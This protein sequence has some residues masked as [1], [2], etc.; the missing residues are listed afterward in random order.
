MLDEI[1][2]HLS[3]P[4][5]SVGGLD[6]MIL[7]VHEVPSLT[8]FPRRN[9]SICTWTV[10]EPVLQNGVACPHEVVK[11]HTR[12]HNQPNSVCMLAHGGENNLEAVGKDAKRI[13]N[14]S[15]GPGKS[16]IEDSLV[17][18]QIPATI[19]LHE[20]GLQCESIISYNKVGYILAVVG[21][22]IRTWPPYDVVM[23]QPS[24]QLTVVVD[25]SI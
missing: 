8:P 3:L 16:V 5:G 25:V 14:H 18:G 20:A 12:L 19:G 23:L 6:L 4:G 21:E 13:L 15:P 17:P 1:P 2:L 9:V 22:W 24:S 10:D 7:N 11:E